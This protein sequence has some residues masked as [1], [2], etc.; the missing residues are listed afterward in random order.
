MIKNNQK[1]GFSLAESIISMMILA[2]VIMLTLSIITRKKTMPTNKTTISGFYACWKDGGIIKQQHYDGHAI[3]SA[4]SSVDCNFE[5][6]RRAYKYYLYA[7][8][9]RK[10][11]IDGQV[12]QEVVPT[13]TGEVEAEMTLNV[14]LGGV[15]NGGITTVKQNGIVVAQALGGIRESASGLVD[16][17][18]K[19]C[20]VIDDINPCAYG[21][22]GQR[23]PKCDVQNTKSE[24]Y[25]QA[26]VNPN[27]TS[28]IINCIENATDND[29]K[30]A[31][32]DDIHQED[33][34][35]VEKDNYH[36]KHSSGASFTV[37]ETD[38]SLK[39]T[40]NFNTQQS[41][42]VKYLKMIPQ[43]MQNG[44]TDALLTYYQKDNGDK[45]G[46]VLIIW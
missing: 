35:D 7:V 30:V 12:V 9:S 38:S 4:T 25:K 11:N 44:L 21:D 46:V 40:A 32:S 6:D 5:M 2:L 14:E 27:K 28:I 18:I 42:F 36:Y 39:A 26:G 10:N 17:N 23:V 13:P 45:D 15:G 31:N 37:Q 34:S 3:K 1:Y 22:F 16:G 19:S 33:L 8:G 43:N 29:K 41:E 20:K 24:S